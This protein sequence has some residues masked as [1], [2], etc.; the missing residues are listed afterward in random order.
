MVFNVFTCWLTLQNNNP[1]QSMYFLSAQKLRLFWAEKFIVNFFFVRFLFA[2]AK[3]QKR[4]L[5]ESWKIWHMLKRTHFTTYYFFTKMYIYLCHI[6]DSIQLSASLAVYEHISL[7]L[8]L[9]LSPHLSFSL[10]YIYIY[11]YISKKIQSSDE[12]CIFYEYMK[13]IVMMLT[14]RGEKTLI[15]LF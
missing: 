14:W 7:S 6:F 12:T 1:Y 3:L 11:I 13:L 15:H 9:S 10:Y 2:N 8:S 5:F 4:N